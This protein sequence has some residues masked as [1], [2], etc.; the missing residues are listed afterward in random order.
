[1]SQRLD[2]VCREYVKQ[3][4]QQICQCCG[5]HKDATPLQQLDW[6]HKISRNCYVLRWMEY[7]SVACCRNCHIEWAQGINEPTNNAIDRIWGEGTCKR[8]E[9]IAKQYQTAKGT[10]LGLIDFR[11]Q[12]E[13][14]Y[15][16]K[17][18]LLDEGISVEEIKTAVWKDFGLDK[19]NVFDE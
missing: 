8:L 10:Y 11:L 7:N 15:K 9:L 5:I 17:L 19:E 13:E 4:D 18:K 14:H 2:K 3:R 1:M 12:L 16:E 6:S